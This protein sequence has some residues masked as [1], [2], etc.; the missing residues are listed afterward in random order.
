[1]ALLSKFSGLFFRAPFLSTNKGNG[2]VRFFGY[3]QINRGIDDHEPGLQENPVTNQYEPV[4]GYF[5][6]LRLCESLQ[7]TLTYDLLCISCFPRL[8]FRSIGVFSRNLE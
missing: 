2:K 8:S 7:A 5:H 3:E 6:N 4:N 1:M